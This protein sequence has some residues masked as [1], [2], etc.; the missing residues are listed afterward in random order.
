MALNNGKFRNGSD[1]DDVIDLNAQAPW[2]VRDNADG[3]GGDDTIWGNIADNLLRGGGGND[4][5]SGWLGNDHILGGSGQDNLFGGDGDDHLEGGSNGDNLY[6]GSGDDYLEGESGADDLR[7]DDGNDTLSGGSNN[8][9]LR[10][11]NGNDNLIGGDGSDVLYGGAGDDL[12]QGDEMPS[13]NG[14]DTLSGG[15]GNDK[16]IGMQ[17]DDTLFGDAGNDE[18]E[19]HYTGGT[20]NDVMFG[21]TGNDTLHSVDGADQLYGDDG[22]DH[23]ELDNAGGR[24]GGAGLLIDGGAGTDTLHLNFDLPSGAVDVLSGRY[25]IESIERLD[26]EDGA[27]QDWTW[28]FDDVRD[29]SDTNALRIEGNTGDTIRLENNVAGHALTGGTWVAGVTTYAG[30]ET[31]THYDYVLNG[32]IRASVSIDTDI[33]VVLV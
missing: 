28:S 31:W 10:G 19:D 9:D 23:I 24:L 3:N 33:D 13:P 26:I 1:D 17:G 2:D 4:Y 14:N 22:S 29:I 15:D 7:G 25:G 21:G 20:G 5:I 16:L 8:D 32:D 12:L 27:D 11:G 6:G 30:G 18:L